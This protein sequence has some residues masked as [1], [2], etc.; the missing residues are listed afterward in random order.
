MTEQTQTDKPR[1]RRWMLV[2][3]SGLLLAGLLRVMVPVWQG[4]TGMVWGD[5][6]TYACFAR[7][8]ARGHFYF[9]GPA[10]E[11]F[12]V[13]AEQGRDVR[14]PV[15]NSNIL[16]NGRTVYTVAMGYPLF[17]SGMLRLG[18]TW[19]LIHA[20]L[21][22][23][24][25]MLLLAGLVVW[26]GLGRSRRAFIVAAATMLLIPRLSATTFTQFSY[27]WREPLFFSCILLGCYAFL[28]F[29]RS[30]HS[31]WLFLM[32]FVMGYACAVKEAN[33]IY[34]P[35]MGLLTL[36]SGA[37]WRR[38]D[39]VRIILVCAICFFAGVA[40]LLIQNTISTGNPLLSAQTIRETDPEVTSRGMGLSAA[41]TSTTLRNYIDIY[42]RKSWFAWPWLLL[43]AAGVVLTAR[44]PVGR[45]LLGLGLA[46]ILLYCQWGN[47]EQRHMYWTNIPYAFFVSYAVLF[48]CE[49]LCA[50]LTR[51][52]YIRLG[53]PT[54]V[55]AALV[56]MP[57]PWKVDKE[58][59]A[60]RIRY[61]DAHRMAVEI[62]KQVSPDGLLLVNRVVR[63]ILGAYSRLHVIRL[64]GLLALRED[65]D[66]CAVLEEMLNKGVPIYFL[67]NT[68][69]DPHHNG[70]VDWA[71]VDYENLQSRFDLRPLLSFD[72]KEYRLTRL[73][74]EP[75]L[76][77]YAVAPWQ[78]S[79]GE[80]VCPVPD[81]GAA[82]LFVHQKAL[83]GSM[84]LDVN[85]V[86]LE[87][88][89]DGFYY[90]PVY[91]RPLSN[92]A[93]ITWRAVNGPVPEMND[94]R[95]VGWNDAIRLNLGADA[96][97]GDA[98][99]FPNGIIKQYEENNRRFDEN[100]VF[101]LPVRQRNDLFTVVG[102]AVKARPGRDIEVRLAGEEQPLF[103]IPNLKNQSAWFPLF[104]DDKPMP[105][106]GDV[107]VQFRCREEPVFGFTEVLAYTART[108]LDYAPPATACG[109]ALE[110][111]LAITDPAY[112]NVMWSLAING[113]EVA[114]GYC[115]PN[116]FMER[117]SISRTIAPGSP[118]YTFDWKNVG[119][120]DPVFIVAEPEFSLALDRP[121]KCFIR[122][123]AFDR[124]R[125]EHGD[126]FAW[127]HETMTVGVPVIPGRVA[128]SLQLDAFDGHPEAARHVTLSFAGQTV[129]LP[130]T[131]ERSTQSAVFEADFSSR[132][133]Q[134]L[135]FTVATWSP[136]E[137]LGSGDD[138][139][140]GFRFYGL[141]WRPASPSL[142]INALSPSPIYAEQRLRRNGR[143][144]ERD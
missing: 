119:L 129:S 56:V 71:F 43:A 70:I 99:Y 19:L 39:K 58:A 14:S 66:T 28:R 51:R 18:G 16:P 25:L 8:L 52:E 41:N 84:R 141:E 108:K 36:C 10:G 24:T 40:P 123:G 111:K 139:K 144:K 13:V 101:T 105:W 89:P 97:P 128:Y 69:K 75:E 74:D 106:A 88:P 80:K 37:F 79:A 30:A 134:P 77:L 95:F 11:A 127:T 5:S 46:H 65:G 121:E 1:V 109:F 114:H 62:E 103:V 94:L 12:A 49:K 98:P 31:R 120:M 47:A 27:L 32:A 72:R 85:D 131:P 78:L 42:S 113:Q 44:Y 60:E 143:V 26:E 112:T 17:L 34:V 55:L 138:R 64:H 107:D 35:W 142:F 67:D 118:A 90:V 9:D 20:N 54:L 91:E 116:P 6:Y 117:F 126:M 63:D 61:S 86:S 48:A 76:T 130:L 122:D 135:S 50:V 125:D 96:V 53:V 102:L 133:L 4:H 124:E 29:V 73:I 22:L 23:L 104:F 57:V 87:L 136:A 15:W 115:G 45:L 2:A 59:Q 81:E 82:Y 137:L 132:G 3:L 33:I 21:I 93:A 83:A 140:L 100:T 68:D 7:L 92:E 110:G 38:T